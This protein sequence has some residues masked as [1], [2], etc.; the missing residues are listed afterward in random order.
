MENYFKEIELMINS[1][2]LRKE[3]L[4]KMCN[5]NLD[6]YISTLKNNS[7]KWIEDKEN[8]RCFCDKLGVHKYRDMKIMLEL[9]PI[10]KLFNYSLN[11]CDDKITRIYIYDMSIR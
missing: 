1:E 9:Q 8:I 4:A 11:S 2:K 7:E 3:E 10:R 5:D 6:L